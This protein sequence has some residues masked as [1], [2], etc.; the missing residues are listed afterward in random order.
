MVSMDAHRDDTFV[1][2]SPAPSWL[3]FVVILSPLLGVIIAFGESLLQ[4][5][6][7]NE[8]LCPEENVCQLGE[9]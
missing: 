3:Q 6:E 7:K 9:L 8:H 2:Q 5:G 1:H 4:V